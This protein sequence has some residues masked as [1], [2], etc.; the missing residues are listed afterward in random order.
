MKL[1]IKKYSQGISISIGVIGILLAL[2]QYF[3]P[4]ERNANLTVYQK[5]TFDAFQIN[6]EIERLKVFFDSTNIQ[7]AGL[8]LKVYKLKLVNNGD[9]D[10]NTDLYDEKIPF[11]IKIGGGTIIGYSIL[12]GSDNYLKNN[13]KIQLLDSNTLE[14]NKIIFDR[15]SFVE[16]E[17]MVMHKAAYTPELVVTG[18][19]E[20]ITTI[21]ITSEDEPTETSWKDW[22]GLILGIILFF[23]GLYA[24]VYIV[25][26]VYY[27]IKKLRKNI[28]SKYI[29]N[30]YGYNKWKTLTKAQISL[31]EIF[32]EFGKKT[33]IELMTTFLDD[34]KAMKIHKENL[35]IVNTV[36]YCNE[37]I[38]KGIVTSKDKREIDYESNFL[39]AV[40]IFTEHKLINLS[41]NSILGLTQ[42]L[43]DEIINTHNLLGHE[44]K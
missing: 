39:F 2:Y 23:M 10:I 43:Y 30:L 18:K 38:K 26:E 9:V 21:A 15:N 42:E 44:K 1:F 3:Y 22:L 6:K 12:N 35:D 24:I 25:H 36:K 29:L 40:D 13:F 5:S 28:R 27:L 33:F 34:K 8:N 19:L 14:F 41:E 16:F 20:G 37:L 4:I 11:G 31:V 32:S 17:I 7:N